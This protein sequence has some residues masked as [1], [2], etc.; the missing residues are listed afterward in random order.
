MTKLG[1]VA[2]AKKQGVSTKSRDT[3]FKGAS[4]ICANF[5]NSKLHYIRLNKTNLTGASFQN[6]SMAIPYE[7]GT[8]IQFRNAN[9]ENTDIRKSD[10]K[11]A[12]LK[13]ANLTEADL[14]GADLKRAKLRGVR[15]CNTKTPWGLDNSGCK[16]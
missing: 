6:I 12:Y 3:K 5:N 2:Y 10:F 9:L 7:T 13:G 14:T 4:L 16:K 15:F 1:L 11:G 8:Y